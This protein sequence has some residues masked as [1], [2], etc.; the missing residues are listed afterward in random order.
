MLVIYVELEK[1]YDLIYV[2]LRRKYFHVHLPE[3][4]NTLIRPGWLPTN[5]HFIELPSI[6]PTNV[7]LNQMT[8]V[9]L[10]RS[11]SYFHFSK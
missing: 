4:W 9:M 11:V 5:A 6:E 1:L 2:C 8:T 7:Q 10:A 3:N